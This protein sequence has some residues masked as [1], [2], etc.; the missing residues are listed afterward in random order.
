MNVDRR[1]ATDGDEPTA[2]TNDTK[3]HQIPSLKVTKV[4]LKQIKQQQS[5]TQETAFSQESQSVGSQ[6]RVNERYNQ[7]DE[8]KEGLED[9]L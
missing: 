5:K 4:P 3:N 1:N 8:S 2:Q 7:L 9:I 6:E